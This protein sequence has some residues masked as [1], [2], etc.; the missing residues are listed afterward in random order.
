MP[1]YDSADAPELFFRL[2]RIDGEPLPLRLPYRNARCSVTK[3]HARLS[4]KQ[5]LGSD[6]VITIALFGTMFGRAEIR[7]IFLESEPYDQL[8]DRY[9]TF[10]GGWRKWSRVVRPHCVA[11]LRGDEIVLTPL[12]PEWA[13]SGLGAIFGAHEW[14]FVRTDDVLFASGSVEAR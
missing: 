6:G 1:L 7:Q 4:R 3:G 13:R 14:H 10:P 9:L 2:E 12:H 5:V 8:N 11:R